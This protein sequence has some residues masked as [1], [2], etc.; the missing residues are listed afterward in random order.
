MD[1]ESG[2]VRLLGSFS[3]RTTDYTSELVGYESP[4]IPVLNQLFVRTA[5]SVQL[6]TIPSSVVR[7]YANACR[8]GGNVK[9][10]ANLFPRSPV[11]LTKLLLSTS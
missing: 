3:E 4:L 5:Q 2:G 8:D 11:F 6:E 9:P 1:F 10:C 7:A